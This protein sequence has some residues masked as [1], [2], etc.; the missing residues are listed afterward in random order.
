MS[1]RFRFRAVRRDRLAGRHFYAVRPFRL[2]F[3][4]DGTMRRSTVLSDPQTRRV[5]ALERLGPHSERL[6]RRRGDRGGGGHRA[7]VGGFQRVRQELRDRDPDHAPRGEAHPQRQERREGLHEHERRDRQQGL[8]QRRHHG[9]SG[10]L[11]GRHAPRREHGRHRHAF[12]HVMRADRERDQRALRPP[13]FAPEGDADARALAQ[14]VRGHDAHHEQRFPCIRA[15][16]QP[17][18]D[19]LLV[20]ERPLRQRDEHRAQADAHDHEERAVGL[21]LVHEVEG[22]RQH[23]PARQRVGQRGEP[24]GEATH[25]EER[26]RAQPARGR[27]EQGHEEHR[28]H[29]G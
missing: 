4:P 12:R 21:A 14:G 2:V 3:E 15:P 10:A 5:G 24:R 19:I 29:G 28:A 6:E 20:P 11:P 7:G 1:A 16:K 25:E 9:P 17:E 8:R 22:R 23:H 13:A 18:P 27:H 26:D